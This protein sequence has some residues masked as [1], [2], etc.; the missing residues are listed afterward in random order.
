MDLDLDFSISDESFK[1]LIEKLISQ[2]KKTSK[3][4]KEDHNTP[5]TVALSRD[6]IAKLSKS[7]PNELELKSKINS[8][9]TADQPNGLPDNI[10]EQIFNWIEKK[11]VR[12]KIVVAQPKND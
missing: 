8:I 9:K 5:S 12:R 7:L 3:D 10:Q 1:E 4:P 6:S 11:R 2:Q